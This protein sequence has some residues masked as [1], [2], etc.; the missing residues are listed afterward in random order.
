M[1][2]RKQR[3]NTKDFKTCLAF[4]AGKIVFYFVVQ[5]YVKKHI[6]NIL[7]LLT[8]PQASVL[9]C[10]IFYFSFCP[11]PRNAGKKRDPFCGLFFLKGF[12]VVFFCFFFVLKDALAL[13][14]TFALIWCDVFPE[15][16]PL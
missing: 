2:R 11:K 14:R 7:T 5:N 13:K 8:Q 6:V 15:E 4:T 1:I 12:T 10:F 3:C 16:V 9:E